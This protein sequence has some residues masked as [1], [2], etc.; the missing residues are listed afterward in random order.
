[1]SA[2]SWSDG[3]MTRWPDYPL[4]IAKSEEVLYSSDWAKFRNLIIGED[5][6][7][8]AVINAVWIVDA[9]RQVPPKNTYHEYFVDMLN[10]MLHDP[11]LPRKLVI[12]SDML[13]HF[14]C[15]FTTFFY[16][17][18]IISIYTIF[19]CVKIQIFDTYRQTGNSG[20]ILTLS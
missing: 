9:I 5:V 2:R 15:S 20:R 6:S 14:K 13:T 11:V 18:C 3:L 4:S 16:S 12:W 7:V 1:M 10:W 17:Q 8:E 19:K